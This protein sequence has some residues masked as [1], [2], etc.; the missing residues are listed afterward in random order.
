MVDDFVLAQ[1]IIDIAGGENEVV[2]AQWEARSGVPTIKVVVNVDGNVDEWNPTNNELPR[3]VLVA[4]PTAEKPMAD[5]GDDVTAY[6]DQPVTFI[7]VGQDPDG[8]IELYEWDFNGDGVYDWSSPN[9]GVTQH[10]YPMIGAFVTRFRVTDDE[11]SNATDFMVVRVIN[12][13]VPENRRPT[14]D[15]GDDVTIY[16]HENVTFIGTGQDIDGQIVLFE[17]DFDCDGVYDWS[18]SNDGITEFPYHIKGTFVTWLRVT[19]NEGSNSTDLKVV[20]VI[21]VPESENLRPIADAGDDVTIFEDE[22]V[23]FLGSGYD[24]DG[25]IELYQW[26]LDGDGTYDWSSTSTGVTENTYP[27]VGSFVTRFKVTDDGGSTAIDFK[28][29]RVISET[30]SD[31]MP[32]IADAGSDITVN[33]GTPAVLVGSAIDPDG[34]IVLFE[35]DFDDNGVFDWNDPDHGITMRNFSTPGY[36]VVTLQVTDDRG[37]T[38]KDM[39]L[40][41]VLDETQ[42][43]NLSPTADAGNDQQGHVGEA[44]LYSGDGAD[45]DGTIVL[46]EWDFDGDGTYDWNGTDHGVSKHIF[47]AAE[48]YITTLRVTDDLGATD[49]DVCVIQVEQEADDPNALPVAELQNDVKV[50]VNQATTLN[51]LGSDSDGTIAKYEWDFD[52]DGI[53]D[54]NGTGS[55]VVQHT[56][57]KAGVYYAKLLVTDYEGASD[58]EV[59]EVVVTSPSD[60]SD[61]G[62]GFGSLVGL[63]ALVLVAL[64]W[65]KRRIADR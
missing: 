47:D 6:I 11:G 48:V 3:G 45:T 26:D 38:S 16:T 60:S 62:S 17:W 22:M 58:T 27:S 10:S 19:D 13:T 18:S 2:W 24:L 21:D 55:G 1:S 37:S 59:C 5:A 9:N 30:L 28:V 51:G 40:V 35:W 44:I 8:T 34:D 25:Q 50:H 53:Y 42:L 57:T 23:T 52:G 54:W 4:E 33:I 15:A 64:V 29:V 39:V 20:R 65:R 36:H 61:D 12:E 43:D 63:T 7:G 46:F 32:P 49:I 41:N 56:Y 31:N 14:A